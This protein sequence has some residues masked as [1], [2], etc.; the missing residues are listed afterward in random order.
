MAM[1]VMECVKVLS[2]KSSASAF[3]FVTAMGQEL[4]LA[5]EVRAERKGGSMSVAWILMSRGGSGEE[6]MARE[7]VPE[8]HA[9]SWIIDP[10]GMGEMRER[11][12]SAN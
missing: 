3:W 10:L 12:C 8:P 5:E 4:E 6:R 1:L 7:T 11:F 9:L 2:L